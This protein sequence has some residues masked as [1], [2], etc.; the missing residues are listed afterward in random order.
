MPKV[1]VIIPVY[2][3]EPYIER[4][5]RSLFE[6]TL[7]DMEY[8]F[9]DD[10][11]P[12]RSIEILKEVLEEYPKREPQVIFERMSVNSGQAA[13]RKRGIE[14]ATGEYII[15]C[16]SDDFVD[17]ETYQLMYE[18][19]KKESL[20]IVIC[21]LYKGDED[22]WTIE[23]SKVSPT[24]DPI[25]DILLMPYGGSL[26]NKFVSS[27]IVKNS[28]II[29]P[30]QDIAEDLALVTQYAVQANAIGHIARPL[31]Y[32]RMNNSSVT[33]KRSCQEVKSNISQHI[34]NLKIAINALEQKGLHDK[35]SRAILHHKLGIKNNFLQLMPHENVTR[36]WRHT[37][38]EINI[39]VPF[40]N[41]VK[42]KEKLVFFITYLGLYP[43]LMRFKKNAINIAH[44]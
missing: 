26:C 38:H 35:Y 37:C 20:D 39:Q 11:T 43:F 44:A 42:K 18:K 27:L 41:I 10:C 9:V 4:C 3:V 7:D 30:S 2:G 14:L 24:S 17:I 8:I 28:N 15:H 34:E 31:Y 36:V 32:Y 29:H 40:S 33:H 19:A 6:Q 21:D 16:D 13:V 1:S 25:D 5:A 12:D 23:K 22:G